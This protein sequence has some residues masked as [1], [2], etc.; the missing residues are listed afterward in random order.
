MAADIALTAIT[1][2]AALARAGIFPHRLRGLTPMLAAPWVPR[3][4]AMTTRKRLPE[5]PGRDAPVLQAGWSSRPSQE[6]SEGTPA[7]SWPRSVAVVLLKPWIR[8]AADSALVGRN[9]SRTEPAAGRFTRADVGRL[10]HSAWEI[11]DGRSRDLPHEPT[12]G[13][14]QNVLLACLT[15][16]MLEALATDGID[17]AYAIELVGDACWK[18]YAQ[19]GQIPRFAARLLARDP[20]KR[21]RLSVEMF[22][23]YPFNQPGYRYDDV[24]EA[25]GRGLDILRCP[26]A[27][28]L[29]SNE[30]SD[31]CVAT[32][33]NL[34][35]PLARM[36]G[37]E[38]ER[39]ATLAAG[40]RRCDFRFR[41]PRPL[42]SDPRV[43]RRGR[44][45][46]EVSRR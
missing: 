35:Y 13:S 24:P 1:A 43:S 25:R 3:V 37:G 12:V 28:Y 17:R 19:W 26:V 4:A 29:T 8:W 9:R 20:A 32:W 42:A 36:W 14:R 6:A 33:C 10:L 34:D 11:F 5:Q 39:H 18:V 15:L 22:L 23:R 16:S 21:M 40:A 46:R 2:P 31:L 41:V 44:P 38:L 7:S 30:A 45:R 27:D